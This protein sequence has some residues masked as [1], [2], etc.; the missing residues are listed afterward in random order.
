MMQYLGR[1]I[2]YLYFITMCI[3]HEYNYSWLF[4]KQT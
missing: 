4:F 1:S 2:L 3:K